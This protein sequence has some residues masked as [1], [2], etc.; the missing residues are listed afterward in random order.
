MILFCITLSSVCADNRK[1]RFVTQD[2]PPFSELQGD[3]VTGIASD[4][5]QSVCH[6]MSVEC[7]ISLLPWRR[8]LLEL[9]QGTADAGYVMGKTE[10]RK[11]WLY[12]S[13]PFLE[14]EYGFFARLDSGFKYQKPA[15]LDGY[16]IATYGPSKTSE[17]LEQLVLAA[18]NVNI[19]IR[20][21]DREGF[22]QLA[23]GRVDLVYSNYEVGIKMIEKSAIRGVHY[24]GKH[25]NVKYY[26]GFSKV[27]VKPEVVEEFNQQ[28]ANL[29]KSAETNT[30][31]Y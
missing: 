14:S 30:Q 12:F 31:P 2:F 21:D 4:I 8:A 16:T 17:S 6:E 5:I 18:N 1:L 26:V 23:S 27:T 28:L 11:Q 24:A 7:D 13:E 9:R 20:P 15:D 29:Q 10:N 25:R 3:A 19:L 22:R